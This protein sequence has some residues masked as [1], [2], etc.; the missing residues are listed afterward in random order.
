MGTCGCLQCDIGGKTRH[1]G[2]LPLPPPPLATPASADLSFNRIKAIEGL[3]SC[4][5]LADLSL[6]NNEI[7]ILEGLDDCLELQVLSVGN[8]HLDDLDQVSSPTA[9][10]GC[11]VHP[12]S[13]ATSLEP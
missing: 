11:W 4:K 12:P 2:W 5:K 13:R 8:N 3:S 7:R 1:A 6:F 10:D 9:R